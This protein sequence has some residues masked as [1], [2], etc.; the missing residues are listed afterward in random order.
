MNRTRQ[1][2]AHIAIV[3][4]LA[5]F[6]AL[7]GKGPNYSYGEQWWSEY[8][9]DKQTDL[10]LHFGAPQVAGRERVKAG[11]DLKQKDEMLETDLGSI[12]KPADDRIQTLKME[13]LAL[14][15]VDESKAAP[16]TVPDYS[17]KRRQVAL[18][19]GCTLKPDVG[20]FGG[21]LVCDGSGSI[22]A[23]V[24][25]VES[26]ETWFKIEAYP[27]A[28]VCIF[29]LAG[30]ESRLLLRPDGKL[31]LRLKHPHGVFDREH[32]SDVAIQ[33]MSQKN[34]D[35]ISPEPVP[36]KEWT[37][38]II[39]KER[40]PMPGGGEPWDA[41]LV[42]NGSV[43]AWYQS[44][45]YNQ[46]GDFFGRQ[47]TRLIVG[48]SA[49]GQQGFAG[50]L[51]EVRV[52]SGERV[53]Y[54]RP[55]MPWRD[56]TASRPL[57]FDRPWFRNDCT[58]FHVSFDKGFEFDRG[59]AGAKVL[60]DL[61][62]Q[63]PAEL[64][65]EGVRGKGWV[66]DPLIGF[67]RIGLAGLNTRAGTLEFWVRPVNWDDVTGYWSHSPPK[68]LALSVARLYARDTKSGKTV[69]WLNF[70]LDRAFNLERAR[71]PVDAGHWL[72]VAIEWRT[73][74]DKY[75]TWA[76]VNGEKVLGVRRPYGLDSVAGLEPA[77]VELGVNN[78]VTVKNGEAP[79]IE[80]D[81]VVGYNVSLE[82]D[83]VRQAQAR[84]QG[85]LQAIP[86]FQTSFEFKYALQKLDFTL[87]PLLPKE[88]QA[89][90]ATVTLV[91]AAGG[92]PVYGPLNQPA[93][94]ADGT[95]HFLLTEGKTLPYGAYR[96]EFV[97]KDKAGK[98]VI[99]GTRDWKFEE[100]PWRNCTAGILTKVPPPWTPIRATPGQLETR[101]TKYL[102]GA[103]GLPT[104]VF[105]DGVNILAAPF[106]LLEDGKPMAGQ[107]T[108]AIEGGEMDANWACAFTGTTCDIAVNCKAEYD[109]MI[110]YEL[111]LKPKGKVG[112]IAFVMP[113][114]AEQATRWLV[115]PVGARGIHVGSVA[116]TDGVV[117][118]SRADPAP[119]EQ[120]KAFVE[121]RKKNPKLTW[122]EYWPPVRDAK[123]AYGFYASVDLN[124]R[125]RGLWWFCDNAAGWAQSKTTGAVEVVRKGDT[126]S[127]VLN[128]VAEP[129][130][131]KPTRPIV[132]AVLP[133]PARP[134]PEKYRLFERV[135][136]KTDPLACSVFDAFLPWPTDPRSHSM[137]L[138]PAPAPGKPEA[139]PSWEY[140]ESCA[141]IMKATKP[142]GYRTMY[143]SR[144]WFSCRA[145][146]Y[147]GWE[148]RS[149]ETGAVSLT[150][151]FNNYLCWE[152][153]EWLRRGIFNAIYLDEC[154]ETPARNLE[155]GFS[156]RLPDGTEQAGVTNFA[157]RDLMKRWRNIFHQ[158]GL[159]PMLLAHHT[160]SFQYPGLVYC[161]A[162]LDGENYPI[163]SLNSA[164]WID[165]VGL[166][167]YEVTQ[168][169]RMWGTTPFWM[170]FVA[171][172]GFDHKEKSQFPKWQW[173][174][175][176]QAQS[177]F[178]HFEI[179]TVYAGQGGDVYKA[180]WHDVLGWGAGDPKLPFVPYWQAAPAVTVAGQ[181]SD[182][183]VSFYRGN[184]RLLLIASNRLKQERELRIT[185]DRKA[186]GLKPGATA[187]ELD[188]GAVP[189]AGEDYVKEQ[190]A[191]AGK[192][193]EK[194]PG[195]WLGEGSDAAT[196]D[197]LE[198]D[199]I[200]AK[201]KQHA[202]VPRF[203]GDTLI[204]PVRA[205]D[206]RVVAIE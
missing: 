48:N 91:D 94:A 173:R 176:R 136:A 92:K 67:P 27:K 153:N 183:L 116:S 17:D 79:R 74:D 96:F 97:S 82:Q 127:L 119:W 75:H 100:E 15:P 59:P 168:S 110:R 35:I 20:R 133:H 104:A 11:I 4:L 112:K 31:E 84:W 106:Q 156:V 14:P 201:E 160:Y 144:A 26:A 29:S 143:L 191:A 33:A 55:P 177:V 36:A 171:E 164:D 68:E 78:D 39:R 24:N 111:A 66:V 89:A 40:H 151:Y 178:A 113:V 167:K 147:D 46:G 98:E 58:A 6:P 56:L 81:E 85:E 200:K 109:G 120:W 80:V 105:A 30:D 28:E 37:H 204:L 99:R 51:D 18:G 145:G 174:M 63:D 90:E 159:E 169:G 185:L 10:L 146:A 149:G 184:G 23:T 102:L 157:F 83:E 138:F 108:K 1:H 140:A 22:E 172:G 206:F 137:Q 155:A 114:R 12:D 87:R 134:L 42:V 122:E 70:P 60:L 41:R 73:A 135:D 152:M 181:G 182:A 8:R 77:Y 13:D 71:V 142:V 43:V 9:S 69:L 187:K 125:N 165:S 25:D 198:D 101:M 86:L 162:V 76:W 197:E 192:V 132:F 50:V 205:R 5:A 121:E 203:E 150:N 88:I 118:T 194:D 131:Y 54:E 195:A 62:G 199:A 123:Q 34:A 103:D 175:A 163:V 117:L 188:S 148:W 193:K 7:A 166:E 38:V 196:N 19:A 47:K 52:S 32:L 72:H 49:A 93:P 124:D 115:Y 21:G 170:P 130:E 139:G 126:V 64:Q 141:P 95:F 190:Q 65:V 189:P 16:G 154:Y 128:L 3:C 44:E 161:D 57:Q 129:G 180:Y 61:K 107:V 202:F 2:A 179:A 158:N 45:R 186:L 53:F